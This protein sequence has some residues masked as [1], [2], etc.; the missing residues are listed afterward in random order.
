MIR[1]SVL[2]A[3]SPYALRLRLLSFACAAAGFALFALLPVHGQAPPQLPQLSATE[4]ANVTTVIN[5]LQGLLDNAEI[6]KVSLPST[7]VDEYNN[8]VY[9]RTS[10][11]IDA[12]KQ[13]LTNLRSKFDHNNIHP[14]DGLNDPAAK[15]Y[16]EG[17]PKTIR[18][19]PTRAAY[20]V[21]GT[22]VKI[23]DTWVDCPDGDIVIDTHFIAPPENNGNPIDESTDAGFAQKWT[24][25]HS[26]VHEKWHERMIKE[27]ENLTRAD[28][29]TWD[30]M[31]DDQKKAALAKALVNAT[32]PEK[33]I[34]VYVAQKNILRLELG[35]LKARSGVLIHA[36]KQDPAELAKVEKRIRWVTKEIDNLEGNMKGAVNKGGKYSFA[37]CSGF[38]NGTLAMYVDSLSSGYWRLDVDLRGGNVTGVRAPEI[39]F[40]GDLYKE[41][42]ITIKPSLYVEMPERIYTGLDVQPQPCQF[43]K[44]ATD[45]G[46]VVTSRNF[47]DI[48]SRLPQPASEEDS[49]AQA[50]MVGIV[51]PSEIH[52]GEGISASVTSNPKRYDDIPAL[53]VVEVNVPLTHD[54]DGSPT[55]Q[56]VNVTLGSDKPQPAQDGLTTQVNVGVANLPVRLT[57]ANGKTTVLDTTVPVTPATVPA[58]PT[59]A[60]QPKDFTTPT[61]CIPNSVQVIHGTFTGD[62][63]VT[64]ITLDHISVPIVAETPRAVYWSV[65]RE[66]PAGTHQVIV[67]DG[68]HSARFEV[69]A[70]SIQMSAD[71]LTLKRGESTPFRAIVRGLEGLPPAAWIAAPRFDLVDETRLKSTA[72]DFR[73]PTAGEPAALLLT[74]RNGSPGIINIPGWLGGSTA[75]TLHSA[76]FSAGQYVYTGTIVSEVT[77]TFSVSDI[78]TPFMAEESGSPID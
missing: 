55:L 71:R 38:L 24:L 3:P 36:R 74:L 26:L 42:P 23:G 50:T 22:H 46:Y 8:P 4:R 7:G 17:D 18:P 62:T 6:K 56:T 48:E 69:S 41:D 20:C 11:V 29:K 47:A 52:A 59:A 37:S 28:K 78:V 51:L 53:Q 1:D 77:G 19:G 66:L 25:L 13:V 57:T 58:K 34:E 70:V 75:I 21:E 65:P 43:L 60:I 72:P 14:I 30:P 39:F 76:D 9:P 5:N 68:A 40:F 15:R 27:Q 35:A 10:D 73:I 2:P 45:Q 49:K 12:Y 44:W 32:T 33:H 16:V 63:R 61:V 64:E 54:S 31:T 67:R